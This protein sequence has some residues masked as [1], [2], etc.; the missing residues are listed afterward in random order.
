MK[1]FALLIVLLISAICLSV[2]QTKGNIKNCTCSKSH[3]MVSEG[4]SLWGN[5]KIVSDPKEFADFNVYICKKY[6]GDLRVMLVRRPARECGEWR[7]VSNKEKAFFSVRFV[8]EP[9]LADF[10]IKFVKSNPGY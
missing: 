2:A 8:E 3:G 1:R 5:V 9:E 7:L 10:T 4:R 6:G